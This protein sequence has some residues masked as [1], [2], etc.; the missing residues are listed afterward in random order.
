MYTKF[1]FHQTLKH[2]TIPFLVGFTLIELLITLA[3]GAILLV[4]IEPLFQTVVMNSRITMLVDGF[5]NGLV[6][7]REAALTQNAS[8]QVCPF[9][10]VNSASCGSSW[11]NGWIIITQPTSGSPVLLQSTQALSQGPILSGGAVSNVTFSAT[12]LALTQS[13]FKVCDSRGAAYARSIEILPTG[14]IQ[15]GP[16]PGVAIWNGG[17]LTCP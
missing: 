1:D 14:F 3:V 16:T 4:F 9:G 12:G 13:N 11:A 2:S 17:A 6:Y 15:S 8:V 5:V 7:A 10:S